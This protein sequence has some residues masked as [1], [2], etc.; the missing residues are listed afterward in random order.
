MTACSPVFI[1][2]S[3]VTELLVI[4]GIKNLKSLHFACILGSS[5]MDRA[6]SCYS[7]IWTLAPRRVNYFC[8]PILVLYWPI[9]VCSKSTIIARGTYFLALVSLKNVA[10][11]SSLLGWSVK[12]PFGWIPCSRQKS[13][14]HALPIWTPAWP[15]WTEMH[16]RWE[17]ETRELV[18]RNSEYAQSLQADLTWN[19]KST[20]DYK[21]FHKT[22]INGKYSDTYLQIGR[23][24]FC[25]A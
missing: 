5:L 18:R 22:G 13:S 12:V 2:S 15:M 20:T 11:E 23:K 3:R 6:L 14:Q 1:F 9:T 25:C 16:S 4:S 21:I 24:I 17:V 19:P 10:K 7:A 8:F